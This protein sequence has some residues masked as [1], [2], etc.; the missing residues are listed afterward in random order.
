MS[1]DQLSVFLQS[2]PGHM[3]R[4]LDVFEAAH[5]N[6]R[7]FCASDTGDYGLVRFVLD[8]PQAAQ[9]ALKAHGAGAVLSEVVC[10]QLEDEP[11]DLARV[12]EVISECNI[13][14]SYAYSMMGTFIVL[15][16]DDVEQAESL[17][18]QYGVQ[19][20]NQSKLDELL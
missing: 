17:L 20:I 15:K 1:I 8:D 4:I 10:I 12:L 19:T 11:G 13:N 7:G 3:K 2:Q 14:V 5:I 6:I 9:A 16:V 18:H